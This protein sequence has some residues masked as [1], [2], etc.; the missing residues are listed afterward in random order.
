MGKGWPNG[1]NLNYSKA[2]VILLLSKT[3]LLTQEK[4]GLRKNK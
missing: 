1:E 3:V 4:L 2:N